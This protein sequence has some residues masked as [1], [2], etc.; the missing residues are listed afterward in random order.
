M[1]GRVEGKAA[2]AGGHVSKAANTAV[3]GLATVAM[4]KTYFDV[5]RDHI[6]M[7]Q[8]FVDD[9]LNSS[10]IDGVTV[11]QVQLAVIQRHQLTLPPAVV[12]T[13]LSR[14][15]KAERLR[16]EGGRYFEGTKAGEVHV[17]LDVARRGAEER[18]AELAAALR[19]HASR[20][21]VEI[22]S[23]EEALDAILEFIE[24][25]HVRLAL[26][27]M[28]AHWGVV[29]TPTE[30]G[31]DDRLVA[32]FLIEAI[33]ENAASEAT[34]REMLEGFV[35]QNTL[36]LRDI[37]TADKPFRNLR[38]FFDSTLLFAALGHYGDEERVLTS[39]L[40]T[41]L[42]ERGAS[43]E[44]FKPTIR[45]MRSILDV[46]EERLGTAAGRRSLYPTELT[47]HFLTTGTTPS[48]ARTIS[49]LLEK[50]LEQL[51]IRVVDTPTRLLPFT[52]DEAA[53]GQ[54]L[55]DRQGDITAPRV[56]HDIDC[57]AAVL[58]LRGGES[59]DS[60]DRARAVFV[61]LSGLT[62]KN[63]NLW[64]REEGG[65]GFPPIVHYYLLS[66]LAWLKRPAS[67]ANLKLRELIALCGAALRPSRET[68]RT[69]IRHLEKL[70]ASG[71]ISSEESAAILASSFTDRY[72]SE[73]GIGDDPD[74]RSLTEVVDRVKA[75]YK[76]QSDEKIK[77]I[78][79]EADIATHR[80]SALE[81]R[82][83]ERAQQI[84]NYLA[85]SLFI[86][87]AVAFLLGFGTNVFSL[88]TGGGFS[89]VFATLAGLPLALGGLASLMWGFNLRAW[90][91]NIEGRIAARLRNWMSD[92]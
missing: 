5:G 70:E 34:I 18:Q 16:R 48:D 10:A 81:A 62:V 57:V 24:K 17:D 67:A 49:V 3:R 12:K 83:T 73:E 41:L 46:Y 33:E 38:V 78:R 69:F 68:W 7:F 2:R 28:E 22:G 39:E 36:L 43:V 76:Q 1:L 21:G 61:S 79:R 71:E 84:G 55:A 9:V 92:S 27:G 4:L 60:L 82:V 63:V 47:R 29:T 89:P 32:S 8:P 44:A 86:F 50:S 52:L 87:L 88:L 45:E 25:H 13:L 91:L 35:L 53:L 64:Y 90:K 19:V 6:A 14:A 11:H 40:L 30:H 26:E 20:R 59:S 85:I 56:Q 75:E 37:S 80:A 74:A 23:T 54:R 66:N 42:Q 15:V 51:G 58:T 31:L 72:L 65:L 77:E